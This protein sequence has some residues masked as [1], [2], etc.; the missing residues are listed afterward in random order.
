[1]NNET[2][3]TV[4]INLDEN[5]ICVL[6]TVIATFLLD[7]PEVRGNRSDIMELRKI[8]HQKMLEVL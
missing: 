1:M 3:K 7:H 4:K 8:V 5:Q 2:L 6:D